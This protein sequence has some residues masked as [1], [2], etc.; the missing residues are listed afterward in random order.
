MI[1]TIPDLI[2]LVDEYTF[3]LR[4]HGCRF[5]ESGFPIPQKEWYLSDWPDVVVTF[6]D[7]NSR[8]V[9]D[10]PRTLL[11]FFCEDSRIFPRLENVIGEMDEYR[12]YMG[13]VGTDATV[14]GGM[15]IEW[16]EMMIL[17][18]QLF[19]AVLGVSGIKVVQNLRIG[20]QSSLRCLSSVPRGVLCASGTLGCDQT[21]FP[22][23][24]RYS[25]KI[26]YMR[27]SGVVLY[28]RDDPIM[29]AQLD[30]A[31]V[32]HRLYRD[33]HTL[34]KTKQAVEYEPGQFV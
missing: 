10:K 31:G 14:T 18:N 5:S 7:R 8:F 12:Q 24:M 15:D 26:F 1:A 28:G 21:E 22:F 3:W 25:E 4:E 9:K 19:L 27:P 23:D 11:C 32:P 30:M 6:R 20:D 29:R 16:Q 13:V 2:N 33:T 17:V 34:Y